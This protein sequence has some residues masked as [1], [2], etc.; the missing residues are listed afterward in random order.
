MTNVNTGKYGNSID[1]V[2]ELLTSS[3]NLGDKTKFIKLKLK[4]EADLAI[5]GYTLKFHTTY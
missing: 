5:T 2:V 4:R 3:E 1:F